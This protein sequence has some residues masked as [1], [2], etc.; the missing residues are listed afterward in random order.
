MYDKAMI[1]ALS[2]NTVFSDED[3]KKYYEISQ[4]M[5]SELKIIFLAVINSK[6]RKELFEN[7]KNLIA[8]AQRKKQELDEIMNRGLK[9]VYM[10]VE[11]VS[12]ESEEARMEALLSS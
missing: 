2:K 11:D 9:K 10:A 7:K 3:K 1:A 5:D 8:Y 4:G 6:T 12:K